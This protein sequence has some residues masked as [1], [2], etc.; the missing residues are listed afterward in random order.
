MIMTMLWLER[1]SSV[2]CDVSLLAWNWDDHDGNDDDDENDDEDKKKE[3]YDDDGGKLN[4]QS[5]RKIIC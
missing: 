5:V 4:E 1:W 3:D 2:H